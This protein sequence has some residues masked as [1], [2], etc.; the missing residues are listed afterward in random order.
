MTGGE[1]LEWQRSLGMVTNGC[2]LS[3]TRTRMEL[4]ANVV[5]AKGNE[6]LHRSGHF[7]WSA[8]LPS[9]ADYTLLP[10]HLSLRPRLWPE[11]HPWLRDDEAGVSV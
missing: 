1:S 2:V 11:Q 5:D 7:K 6:H 10:V 9:R 8:R 4:Q 3:R